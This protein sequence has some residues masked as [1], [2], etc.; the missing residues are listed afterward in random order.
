MLGILPAGEFHTVV[1][2]SKPFADVTP[3]YNLAFTC[4]NTSAMLL[5]KTSYVSE[6]QWERR[7][8]VD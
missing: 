5:L 1:Y 7:H 6:L 8:G 4:K 3:L 2:D